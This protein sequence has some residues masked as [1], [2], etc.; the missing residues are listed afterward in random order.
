MDERGLAASVDATVKSREGKTKRG[1]Y[2]LR[3][4][5]YDFRAQILGGMTGALA[6]WETCILSSLLTNCGTWM[7]IKENT[8]KKCEALQNLYLQVLLKLPHSTP[9]LAPRAMCGIWSMRARIWQ[10]KLRLV[11]ALKNLSEETL[12]KEIYREQQ[13]LGLPGL[14]KEAQEI[15]KSIGI[16]DITIE[17][18]TKEEV[19]DA[20]DMYNLKSTKEEM[21][22]KVKYKDMKKEDFRKP[23][24][25]LKEMNL[26][27]CSVA[28]RLKCFMIDCPGNM[29][30][31]YKGR[32]ECIRCK[33]KS[34]VEGP[35]MRET[36]DHLEVCHGYSKYR[37]GRDMCNFVHKVEYFTEIMKERENM[38]VRIRKAREKK[39][40]KEKTS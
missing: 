30:N 38:F 25:F 37:E 19:E 5:C 14:V 3:S 7:D 27:Q 32:E 28:M 39:L 21:G 36:Q 11:V 22:D 6:L 12:A 20:L 9:S 24:S 13:E 40:R 33:L 17:N 29:R 15:C 16:K 4:V 2:E 26:E 18:V 1:I 10:E 34:G 35:A 23:Q 31:K 8:I